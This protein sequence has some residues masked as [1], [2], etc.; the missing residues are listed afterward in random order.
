MIEKTQNIIQK[1]SVS[2][3]IFIIL[4]LVIL[5]MIP[6]QMIRSVMNERQIRQE[7]ALMEIS[8]KWGSSQV[9]AGPVMTIPYTRY[10]LNDKMERVNVVKDR[11]F[12][13]PAELNIH[14]EM[15]PETRSRGI[16]KVV[17]YRSV[18][19]MTGSFSPQDTGQSNQQMDIEWEKARVSLG[20]SDMKGI[21]DSVKFLWN[22]E[23]QVTQPGVHVTELFNSGFSI[24]N[25][26]GWD[27][28]QAGNT[29][30]I[31]INLNGSRNLSFAPVGKETSVVIESSWTDPSFDG[32][33]LPAERNVTQDGFTASWKILEFNRNY[34]QQWTQQHVSLNDSTFGVS[35]IL[36]VDNYQIIERSMKYAI[37]FFAFTFMVFFFIEILKKQRIHPLQYALVGFGLSL[38]YLMLLSLAEHIGFGWAYILASIGIISLITSYSGAIFKSNRLSGIMAGFLVLVYGILFI[39]L[40]LQ[41]F[42][43]LLGSLILFIVLAVVMHFSVKI[44]WDGGDSK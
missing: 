6:M 10:D 31:E 34:P 14:A 41:D 37:L 22:G 32:A 42:A 43:L 17:V 16:F 23:E 24:Q 13:L 9:V 44:D 19:K 35:L 11:F 27:S 1:N 38:F 40:Q 3:K 8:S 5:L 18:I 25:P 33:F 36:P 15:I 7:E 2:I 21:S 12:V 4:F 20:V 28:E 39:L 29:F 30:T 26:A